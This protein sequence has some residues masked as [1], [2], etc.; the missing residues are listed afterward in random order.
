MEERLTI[1]RCRRTVLKEFWAL[2]DVVKFQEELVPNERRQ[3]TLEAEAKH[4]TC[5]AV[6]AFQS[7]DKYARIYHNRD[8]SHADHDSI[9]AIMRNGFSFTK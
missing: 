9:Y 5:G 6:S 4:L 8:A 1:L 2:K 3:F 7:G